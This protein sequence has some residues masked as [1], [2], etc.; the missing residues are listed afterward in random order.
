[1]RGGYGPDGFG[2]D[3]GYSIDDASYKTSFYS[4]KDGKNGGGGGGAPYGIDW[5][6][7]AGNGG[8]GLVIITYYT[9]EV[10]S[11]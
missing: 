9:N 4:G 11:V 10:A 6:T 7:R 2:G 5:D 8:D 1:M 3:G